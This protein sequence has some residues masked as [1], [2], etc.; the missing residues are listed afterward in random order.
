KVNTA[1]DRVVVQANTVYVIPP[2]KS[3]SIL[4]G[5]LHLF[6]PVE[7]RGVRLPIDLFFRS[8]ADDKDDKSIGIILSGMGSDGSL[9]LRSIKERGGIALVQE[10]HTAKF[11]S[12]PHSALEAVMA[13]IVAPAEELPQK[14]MDFMWQSSQRSSKMHESE[15]NTGALEKIILLLRTRTG[16]D[17]SLYK[18]TTLYRRV[19]R[20]MGI[21]QIGRIAAYVRYLQENPAEGEILFRELLIGVTNFFRDPFI[22][23]YL[24]DK[25]FPSLIAKADDGTTFRAWVPAC[26][27]GEEAY[28]LAIVFKE[29]MESVKPNKTLSLLIFGTDLDHTAIDKARKAAYPSNISADVSPKRLNRFFIKVEHQYR[30]STEIREMLVFAPQNV[31]KDPPF[32]KLDIIT[33]RNLMIYLESELQKKLL[34]LFHYSLKPDGVL[35]LGNAETIGPQDELFQPIEPKY[36][37]YK[38]RSKVKNAG[39]T[40][41]PASAVDG[42]YHTGAIPPAQENAINVQALTDRLLLQKFSPPGI[43]VTE[44][45]DIVYLTGET[46]KYLTIPQGRANWNLFAMA[47]E[48]LRHALPALLRKA[49][50][51]YEKIIL[52]NV[53]IAAAEGELHTDITIQQI[54]RPSSLQ[55]KILLVFNDRTT[56]KRSSSTLKNKPKSEKGSS[57]G[58]S[59]RENQRLKSELQSTREEM[60]TSQEELK[61]MNEELQ[62]TNEE[63]QSTNEE[64]TTSKEEMQS[65]NEELHTVNTELQSKVDDLARVNNDMTNLLNSTEIAT[66][67]LDKDLKIRQF[68]ISTTKIFKLIQS[69]IGRLFTDQ[70]TKLEYP[71]IYDDAKEVLRTLTYSEKTVP[72]HG[73]QWFTVRIMP[74]RT[75]DDKIDGIVMTFIDV[76][77]AKT[78]ENSLSEAG[79]LLRSLIT[80]VPS[81]ILALSPEGKIIECNPEAERVFF[82]KRA[83][84]IGKKYVDLFIPDPDRKKTE[85]EIKELLNGAMPHRYENTVRA[86]NGH[87]FRVEWTAHKMLDAKGN[88]IGIITVGEKKERR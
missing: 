71:E 43:L 36:R 29:A 52:Q 5:T 44:K 64:L 28:S 2:N 31:I 81:V 49:T 26:S 40:D 84:V 62:S 33:C 18:K 19:E 9:G 48:G 4:N 38:C 41:F 57:H 59:V 24:R 54:D 46:E 42:Y 51:S 83:E 58:A 30:L 55:G 79:A 22:W 14:L 80:M 76:T 11:D 69:D 67:F 12:M 32:T 27:T 20:R 73:N 45:G 87:E 65:L 6:D 75:I 78:L 15:K 82:C 85:E 60:Q 8:L 10:P 34:A 37:I 74:Y 21:H 7:T 25:V 17:F 61:S 1:T 47:R 23:E 50:L 39:V 35:F 13:D 88:S 63:L 53:V 68:T 77:K 66:L 56:M 70:V 72:A 86:A 3:M 16:H